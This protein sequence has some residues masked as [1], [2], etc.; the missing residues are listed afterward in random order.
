MGDDKQQL[1]N[2]YPSLFNGLGKLKNHKVKFH[3]DSSV[4]PVI[5][6]QRMIPYYLRERLQRELDKMVDDDVI[7]VQSGPSSW[8]SN[9][10]SN[11]R[12]TEE[13][14]QF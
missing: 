11:P 4:K 2:K 1:I 8:V 7:E 3:I 13:S 5:K 12:M 14:D 6:K 9:L 10:P